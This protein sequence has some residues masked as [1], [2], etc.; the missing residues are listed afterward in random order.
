MPLLRA[1]KT[2]KL[3]RL[4]KPRTYV[5]AHSRQRI[6]LTQ[7]QASPIE[8]TPTMT[9]LVAAIRHTSYF[10]SIKAKTV[11]STWKSLSKTSFLRKAQRLIVHASQPMANS[12]LSKSCL[13]QFC[14]QRINSYCELALD[15]DY[16]ILRLGT[17]E[18]RLSVQA[19][20]PEGTAVP[21]L[22]IIS[23]LLRYLLISHNTTIQQT[24]PTR[25]EQREEK[26]TQDRKSKVKDRRKGPRKNLRS[27][28]RNNIIIHQELF[29]VLWERKTVG[30]QPSSGREPQKESK[31]FEESSHDLTGIKRK[32]NGK[33]R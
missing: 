26:P 25:L 22:G 21:S 28:S 27:W 4:E 30:L 6:S 31:G 23:S 18:K 17:K 5:E 12:S 7:I 11:L 14:S 24:F 33:R 10:F 1:K 15:Y 8:E 2:P 13:P 19:S 29:F 3:D 20:C 9:F 32:I 16:S